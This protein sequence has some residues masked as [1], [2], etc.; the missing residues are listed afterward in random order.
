MDELD[1][2]LQMVRDEGGRSTA[3]RRIVLEALARHGDEG[4]TAERLAEVI[5]IEHPSFSES[6]VYRSLECFERVGIASHSHL[7]HGPALWRLADHPHWCAVCSACGTAIGVS[8]ALMER[9]ARELRRQSG[10]R[11]DGHF[12]ITGVCAGC[13]DS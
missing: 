8:P 11:I 5:R 12:A 2:A 10:F 1:Q 9:L 13:D 7:G 4:V 6:T 3:T